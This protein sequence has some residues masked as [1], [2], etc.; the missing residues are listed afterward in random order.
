MSFFGK[1]LVGR[2]GVARSGGWFEGQFAMFFILE[3]Q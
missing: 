1:I 3:I 2:G